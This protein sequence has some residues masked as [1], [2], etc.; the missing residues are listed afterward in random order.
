MVDVVPVVLVVP[1]VVSEV[2]VLA[3]VTATEVPSFLCAFLMATG[4]VLCCSL[5]TLLFLASL[6]THEKFIKIVNELR[7]LVIYFKARKSLKIREKFRRLAPM[8]YVVLRHRIKAVI[9][10]R[11]VV[12]S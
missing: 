8:C 6:E 7:S 1:D 12:I 9:D 11:A 5:F 3:A 4:A 10:D 2:V